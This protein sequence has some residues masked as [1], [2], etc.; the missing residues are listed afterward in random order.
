MKDL[1]RVVTS[2]IGE[3]ESHREMASACSKL[4]GWIDAFR[5]KLVDYSDFNS[6]SRVR[7]SF[8][9]FSYFSIPIDENQTE[10]NVL[11][12]DSVDARCQ[13]II[14]GLVNLS[15]C[16]LLL[17]SMT[18]ALMF[19][20][21]VFIKNTLRPYL[22]DTMGYS[23]T[24]GQLLL[25]CVVQI[26][27]TQHWLI[28][29]LKTFLSFSI[30]RS[31]PALTSLP[32]SKSTD[33]ARKRSRRWTS[34]STKFWLNGKHRFEII[35]RFNVLTRLF[36]NHPTVFLNGQSPASFCYFLVYSFTKTI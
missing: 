4:S 26:L 30:V 1:E 12:Q 32:S 10:A 33:S 29:R 16:L 5:D 14:L 25:K 20:L 6:S 19:A 34:T 27:F 3:P 22:I 28:Q 24:K 13:T 7:V 31:G 17:Y 23:T 2:G 8:T 15:S 21:L 9:L 18:L 36:T 35:G 11:A